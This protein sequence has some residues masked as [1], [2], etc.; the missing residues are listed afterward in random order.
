MSHCSRCSKGSYRSGGGFDDEGFLKYLL[1][2][3]VCVF[4]LYL[5]GLS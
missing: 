3:L 2:G 4:I 5:I 1:I